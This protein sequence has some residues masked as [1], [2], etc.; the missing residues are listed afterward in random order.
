MG[1]FAT[2]HAPG[3]GVVRH[4]EKCVHPPR[5][6]FRVAVVLYVY[7]VHPDD[8]CM[9][10]ARWH[11]RRSPPTSRGALHAVS[12]GQHQ[13]RPGQ[14]TCNRCSKGA[15]ALEPGA[16]HCAACQGVVRTT[17]ELRVARG[18]RRAVPTVPIGAVRGCRG[19]ARAMSLPVGNQD[20]CVARSA[21]TRATRVSPVCEMP[22]WEVTAFPAPCTTVGEAG[23]GM[24]IGRSEGHAL[25]RMGVQRLKQR[26][27]SRRGAAC[28]QASCSAQGEA[29]N[30]TGGCGAGESAARA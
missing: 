27:E 5:E 29:C 11:H 28:G 13:P 2:A 3:G 8:I 20:A 6:V 24:T 17:A 21:S 19:G 16:T 12:A 1:R 9:L 23:Q 7:H 15:V 14:V 25:T 26:W 22:L 30:G 4:C 18:R 10:I